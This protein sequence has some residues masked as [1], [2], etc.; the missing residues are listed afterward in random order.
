M[1]SPAR[2]HAKL[3]VAHVDR[4]GNPLRVGDRVGFIMRGWFLPRE[5]E[6]FGI[7]TEI[8]ERGGIKIEAIENY[9]R[10]TSSGNPGFREKIVFFTHHVYDPV[11]K[12]RKYAKQ[13]GQYLLSLFRV[14]PDELESH[15]KEA[16]ENALENSDETKRIAHAA[17][18]AAARK[19]R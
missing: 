8:D 3:Q 2:T 19:G 15:L 17:A 12:A 6:S 4:E 1:S 10:F 9:R 5:Q 11:L 7:I 13:E 18:R 16:L 14:N